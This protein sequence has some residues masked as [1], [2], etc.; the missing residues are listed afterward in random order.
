MDQLLPGDEEDMFRVRP[1]EPFVHTDL[2]SDGDDDLFITYDP[3]ESGDFTLPPLPPVLPGQRPMI[4]ASSSS[5]LKETGLR[6]E[7]AVNSFLMHKSKLP[8]DKLPLLFKQFLFIYFRK[9]LL[10][11]QQDIHYSPQNLIIVEDYIN[12]PDYNQFVNEYESGL[13]PESV[14]SIDFLTHQQ[15]V[16][17]CVYYFLKMNELKLT[18]KDVRDLDILCLEGG[19]KMKKYRYSK[20]SKTKLN[21]KYKSRLQSRKRR[22]HK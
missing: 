4:K 12:S 14:L 1:P 15:K 11:L 21:K 20:K 19:K 17:L 16:Y 18:N 9:L 6:Y 22:R 10:E 8:F 13:T 7:D 3:Y 2:K 5:C